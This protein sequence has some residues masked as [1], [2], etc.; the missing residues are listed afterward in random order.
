MV[1]HQMKLQ[2]SGNIQHSKF[3]FLGREGDQR[4]YC[5]KGKMIQDICTKLE[6]TKRWNISQL[7]IKSDSSGDPI[8]VITFFYLHT[9]YW[10]HWINLIIASR[11]MEWWLNLSLNSF[12][13]NIDHRRWSEKIAYIRKA[14]SK[15]KSAKITLQMIRKY[16]SKKNWSGTSWM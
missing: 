1:S 13:V 7:G 11:L 8:W 2:L 12:R 9:H 5:S 6:H 15:Q 10:Q 4:V 14:N 3:H 16:F